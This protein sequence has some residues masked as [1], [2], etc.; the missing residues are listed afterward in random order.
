L[1]NLDKNDRLF[2]GVPI[3]GERGYTRYTR[4]YV[5][6][7]IEELYPYFKAAFDKGVK[8]ATWHQY[9][10]YFN[11]GE[12]CEFSVYDLSVT[13]N[14][15]VAENWLD[16][17]FHEDR[18]VEVTKEA[19][20]EEKAYVATQR[21]SYFPYEEIDGKYYKRYEEGAYDYIPGSGHPDGISDVDIPVNDLEFQDALRSVF[22]DHTQVV[23]TPTR[24]VQFDYEHE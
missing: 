23:V 10:P 15:E 19:Y 2:M 1:T 3:Q 20:D 7:P 6:R 24:V 5:P 4:S 16:D 14:E 17:N 8:A 13:N 21:W 22:G 12:P 9:T 11:D 18:L